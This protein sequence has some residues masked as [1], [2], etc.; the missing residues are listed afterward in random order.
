MSLSSSNGFS[1]NSQTFNNW[2]SLYLQNITVCSETN[3]LQNLSLQSDVLFCGSSALSSPPSPKNQRTGILTRLWKA[4]EITVGVG[5]LEAGTAKEQWHALAERRAPKEEINLESNLHDLRRTLIQLEQKRVSQGAQDGSTPSPISSISESMNLLWGRQWALTAY[6]DLNK[7]RPEEW[8]HTGIQSLQSDTAIVDALMQQEKKEMF[9]SLLENSSLSKYKNLFE[10][11]NFVVSPELLL[12]SNAQLMSDSFELNTLSEVE[13]L[14][15]MLS[16]LEGS[17]NGTLTLSLKN[18]LAAAL[19]LQQNVIAPFKA[20]ITTSAHLKKHLVADPLNKRLEQATDSFKGILSKQLDLISAGNADHTSILL[21][22]GLA[23][24]RGVAAKSI[25]YLVKV[26]SKALLNSDLTSNLAKQFDTETLLKKINNWAFTAS[27]AA[28]Y[29]IIAQPNGKFTFRIHENKSTNSESSQTNSFIPVRINIEKETLLSDPFLRTLLET[30]LIGDLIRELPVH[31]FTKEWLSELTSNISNSFSDS[32]AQMQ[33]KLPT[34]PNAINLLPVFDV[35]NSI[36]DT[37]MGIVGAKQIK[38]QDGL[39]TNELIPFLGGQPGPQT[40]ST[41][42]SNAATSS[43]AEWDS[44]AAVL[45]HFG[46]THKE[47][48]KLALAVRL[49]IFQRYCSQNPPETIGSDDKHLIILIAAKES[50]ARKTLSLAE[51][52][53][54]NINDLHAIQIVISQAEQLAFQAKEFERLRLQKEAPFVAFTP[55]H[56]QSFPLVK[57]PYRLPQTDTAFKLAS[58]TLY[59]PIQEIST[60]NPARQT[61][62]KD[63]KNFAEIL[64]QE[65]DAKNLAAVIDGVE[66]LVEKMDIIQSW[67]NKLSPDAAEQAITSISEIGRAYFVAHFNEEGGRYSDPKGLATIMVL[68]GMAEDLKTHLPNSHELNGVSALNKNLQDFLYGDNGLVNGFRLFDPAWDKRFTR[69]LK[70]AEKAHKNNLLLLGKSKSDNFGAIG[71]MGFGLWRFHDTFSYAWPLGFEAFRVSNQCTLDFTPNGIAGTLFDNSL[72]Y[73]KAF[74]QKFPVIAQNGTQLEQIATA[75]MDT[76]ESTLPKA[77]YRLRELGT[78]ARYFLR[79]PFIL[80]DGPVVNR[81]SYRHEY[82]AVHNPKIKIPIKLEAINLDTEIGIDEKVRLFSEIKGVNTDLLNVYPDIHRCDTTKNCHN[83]RNTYDAYQNEILKYIDSE[84]INSEKH[85]SYWLSGYNYARHGVFNVNTAMVNHRKTPFPGG[86]DWKESVVLQSCLSHKNLQTTCLAGFFATHL[87]LLEGEEKKEW[88]S[89]LKM[90]LFEPGVLIDNL[91]SSA[92]GLDTMRALDHFCDKGFRYFYSRDKL[93]EA[94]FIIDISLLLNRYVNEAN[95]KIATSNTSFKMLDQQRLTQLLRK[96]TDYSHTLNERKKGPLAGVLAKQL[97]EE[98]KNYSDRELEEILESTML[99]YRYPAANQ[100]TDRQRRD[101]IVTGMHRIAPQIKNLVSNEPKRTALFQKLLTRIA[102]NAA[103][104]KIVATDTSGLRFSSESKNLEIDLLEGRI[105]MNGMGDQTLPFAVVKHPAY[106]HIFGNKEYLVSLINPNTWEFVDEIGYQCRINKAEDGKYLF[107]RKIDGKHW[108]QFV[109]ADQFYSTSKSIINQKIAGLQQ[110]DS[111]TSS[112]GSLHFTNGFTHWYHDEAP[113]EIIM[114]DHYTQEKKYKASLAHSATLSSFVGKEMVHTLTDLSK[115]EP[116]KLLNIYNEAS[117]YQWL[118]NVEDLRYV[119]IWGD[120][121]T[122]MP[123]RIELPRYQQ[124]HGTSEISAD[125]NSLKTSLSFTIKNNRAFCDQIPDFY[126]EPKQF[127]KQLSHLKALLVLRNKAGD[128]KIILPAWMPNSQSA[129]SLKPSFTDLRSKS[130]SHHNYIVLEKSKNQEGFVGQDIHANLY[131]TLILQTQHRYDEGAKVLSRYGHSP[132]TYKNTERELLHT[133]INFALEKNLDKQPTTL[134]P[135]MEALVLLIKDHKAHGSQISI[136]ASQIK[137]LYKTYYTN[138]QEAGVDGLNFE[139]GALVAR[140]LLES[141]NALEGNIL[142]QYLLAAQQNPIGAHRGLA[143]YAYKKLFLLN[144]AVNQGLNAFSDM[145]NTGNTNQSPQKSPFDRIISASEEEFEKLFK[146]VFKQ[147]NSFLSTG[148]MLKPTELEFANEFL[149][150]AKKIPH[151]TS[152]ERLEITNR[153]QIIQSDSLI[154][155]ALSQI[156]IEATIKP[157]L[158]KSI[159]LNDLN[160]LKKLRKIVIKIASHDSPSKAASTG[161]PGM[162]MPNLNN[163]FPTFK[164]NNPLTKAK[165]SVNAINIIPEK[166]AFGSLVDNWQDHIVLNAFAQNSAQSNTA[167]NT[168][169]KI[170]EPFLSQTQSQRSQDESNQ[171]IA[172]IEEYVKNQ[173]SGEFSFSSSDS[174][175]TMIENREVVQKTILREEQDLVSRELE[176]LTF[177][178]QG[179]GNDADRVTKNLEVAK[180]LKQRSILEIILLFARD[181]LQVLQNENN[182]SDAELIYGKRLIANYL[183]VAKRRDTKKF[184][185]LPLLEK[186]AALD[187]AEF[188]SDKEKKLLKEIATQLSLSPQVDSEVQP[189]V[190]GFEFF[191]RLLVRD[192]QWEKIQELQDFFKQSLLGNQPKHL[193]QKLEMGFGKTFLIM[194]IYAFCAANGKRIS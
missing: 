176:I 178:M 94:A 109:P 128:Q 171:L 95:P 62:V 60:W 36:L 63:I 18:A 104:L 122:G 166:I 29:E 24:T 86:L 138:T 127:H 30:Q 125:D 144:N 45:N 154:I 151:A 64:L 137:W 98:Y 169:Q 57:L 96:K 152:K 110:I 93:E 76:S 71:E 177:F 162:G 126:L 115:K 65:I 173:R 55:Q 136:D 39:I 192:I 131:H 148:L 183:T 56:S 8:C 59:Q 112:F 58:H 135:A 102:P 181:D 153:C 72:P 34:G 134:L 70:Q 108:Y 4:F 12:A 47:S 111:R 142:E 189:A 61:W 80:T 161:Q 180:G 116:L 145:F 156:I 23:G 101:A 100:A 85:R 91:R 7:D 168:Y 20:S 172:S 75:Y 129:L 35:G 124:F 132:K 40:T 121:Q 84:Y 81:E 150:L 17:E 43:S 167:V 1:F 26:I 140:Y 97:L 146:Q 170:L 107:S 118:E 74:E 54:F 2:T 182:L 41:L 117:R 68:L 15:T 89:F 90:Y 194:P 79:S 83:F 139:N 175:K 82:H 19:E 53:I 179:L 190:S 184:G 130:I 158:L 92:S 14:S 33:I 78:I 9:L 21:P 73:W 42:I 52:G 185:L 187:T 32:I 186:L 106:Q 77:F 66:L 48:Q 99:Y 119:L 5:S 163:L 165:N 191:N 28:Y 143:D 44:L 11:K 37:I 193:I 16:L 141:E 27:Q 67:N 50:L 133:I 103:G 113:A 49:A 10:N 51:Q 120:H 123:K 155:Q 147:G 188:N 3:I 22:G 157:A 164:V 13:L 149:I 105:F 46:K 69:T 174:R 114:L 38:W 88:Q 25:S 160:S 31:G 6:C 159:D 87:T